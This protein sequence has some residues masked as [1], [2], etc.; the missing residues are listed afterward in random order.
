MSVGGI[1]DVV[2]LGTKN[3]TFPTT[4]WLPPDPFGG[5]KPFPEPIYTPP[6]YTYISSGLPKEK[7]LSKEEK[8]LAQIEGI[9]KAAQAYGKEFEKTIELIA[10]VL[11]S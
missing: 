5:F 3:C 6:T 4:P 9:L 7:K 8:K 1:H 11:N 2:P 10:E